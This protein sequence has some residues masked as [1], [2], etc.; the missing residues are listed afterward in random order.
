VKLIF[1][2]GNPGSQYS[3]TR[4]N[5]GFMVVERVAQNYNIEFSSHFFNS[6]IAEGVFPCP[7][8]SG[9][10]INEKIFLIKPQTY[11]NLSGVSVSSIYRWYKGDIRDILVICDDF[12]LPSGTLRF[13]EKGSAGGHNGLKSII[14][15][16]GNN[17][18]P[19]LRIGAGNP[20]I[21]NAAGYVLSEIPEK[22]MEMFYI[23]I[24]K[25]AEGI[26]CFIKNGINMAMNLYNKKFIP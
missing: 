11:M 4:H 3:M 7:S 14:N 12:N 18:F 16:L 24:E 20:G 19:R 22:E 9:K 13:R 26:D 6:L 1:G 15:L 25:A 21:D 23:I 5:L 8:T 2:L 17:N 10:L